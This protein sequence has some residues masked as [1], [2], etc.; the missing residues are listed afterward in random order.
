MSELAVYTL[1]KTNAAAAALVSTR[2][3]ALTAPQSAAVPFLTYQR[4]S[5][6]RTRSTRG[7]T[8]RAR[9]R[10]QVDAYETTYGKAK[11]LAAAVRQALDGYAGGAPGGVRVRSIALENE[12]DLY[13]T[14]AGPALYRVSLDFVVT[15]DET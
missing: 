14:D 5:G 2:I 15:H 3:Y 12:F 8:G 1:L 7:P 6:E 11:A 10:V 9:A 4:I 13:E